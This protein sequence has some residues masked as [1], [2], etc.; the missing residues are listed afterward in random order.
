MAQNRVYKMAIA[1]LEN[2]IYDM[3]EELTNEVIATTCQNIMRKLNTQGG[4]KQQTIVTQLGTYDVKVFN[5]DRN[6]W[7]S[8]SNS[9]A[10]AVSR[11]LTSITDISRA[12]KQDEVRDLI[13]MLN[14]AWYTLK[15]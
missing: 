12:V 3:Q 1:E 15:N 5:A 13:S 2:D 14:E 8:L 9:E 10:T 6:S 4:V 7:L 11:T